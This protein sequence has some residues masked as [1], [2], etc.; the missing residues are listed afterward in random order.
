MVS[1]LL[2]IESFGIY[3]SSATLISYELCIDTFRI[4][5]TLELYFLLFHGSARIVQHKQLL[6]SP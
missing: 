3:N 2:T 5:Q 1:S 4:L 6:F